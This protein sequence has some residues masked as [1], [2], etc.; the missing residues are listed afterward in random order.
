MSTQVPTISN[1]PQAPASPTGVDQFLRVRVGD[2]EFVVNTDYVAGVYKISSAYI[3]T[4]RNTILTPDGEF[5]AILLGDVVKEHFK[6][7][8]NV[9]DSLALV[10]VK[11]GDQTSM[12]RADSVS[13]PL[14]IKSVHIHPMPSVAIGNS[15]TP[16][17]RSVVNIDPSLDIASNCVCMELDPRVA[18]GET[19]PTAPANRPNPLPKEATS[20][21]SG[22]A[23]KSSHRK[24]GQLL[25]FVPEDVSRLEVEQVFCLPLT[26]IAEVITT[27]QDINSSLSTDV[28]DGFVLWRKVPVPVVQL[29]K[30][31]GF[32][33][34]AT[35]SDSRRLVIAR[36]TGN[37]FVG[38]YAQP[39]MQTL[40]VPASLPGSENTLSGRPHLGCFLTELGELVV[41]D[42]N[43]ILD[44]DF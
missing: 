23:A 39:Q 32:A 41:P 6:M 26:A 42:M 24:S 34:E 11:H 36:A 12:L 27:Q 8:P 10:A 2:L 18:V 22:S 1:K 20:A 28:C 4:D 35:E 9:G 7:D 43:R 21:L 40:K 3:L 33:A 29:G 38:F 25:A 5:P 14:R 15:G 16:L 31:F 13:S 44:N 17:T 30:I 37:R 19:I